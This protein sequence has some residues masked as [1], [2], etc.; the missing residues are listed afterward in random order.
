MNGLYSRRAVVVRGSGALAAISGLASLVATPVWGK[1]KASRYV[2][3]LDP[4]AGRGCAKGNKTGDC[5]GCKACHKHAKNKRF[6]TKKAAD[7][8]RAHPHCK[9]KVR[10]GGKISHEAW[11]KLFGKPGDVTRKQIDLRNANRLAI[12]KNGRQNR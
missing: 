9:C 8:H 2:W 5:T 1:K 10:R 12:F 7:N 6:P 11:V 4:N 3:R